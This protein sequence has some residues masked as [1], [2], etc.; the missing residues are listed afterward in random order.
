LAKSPPVT[1]RGYVNPLGGI[2]SGWSQD[3]NQFETND[4]LLWPRS[5]QTFT[6]MARD[7][8]R[9]SSILQAISLPIRLTSWRIDACGASDEVTRHVADDLGLPI[10]GDDEEYPHRR[11]KG[12]FSWGSHLQQALTYLQFGHSIFETI[13]RV[14]GGRIH[15]AK[16]APRPQSTIAWWN[17]ARDGGL[18]SVE[19][20]P[21]GLFVTP[22]LSVSSPAGGRSAIPISRLLVYVRDPDPGVWHGNSILRPAYKNYV[23]KDELLRIEA[24]AA[25][26]HGIGVPAAWAPPDESNDPERVAEYQKAASAYQGGSSAGIG[27]PAEARFEILGPTGSPM[28]P[29]RAIEY[30]DHQM[31]LVALAHFLNLDGKGGS[32]ALASVQQ[33]TFVQ[34]VGAVA[35]NIREVAQ[36]HVIDDI[37]DWNYGQDEPAPRLVF[38]AI[39]S[40]QD[41]TAVAMQQLVAA[42]LLTPDSRL[43]SFVRQMTG[44]PASDSSYTQEADDDVE[45]APDT[46]Q[47]GVE[48]PPQTL[49]NKNDLRLFDV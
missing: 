3:G 25:R 11:S 19:Q 20:W 33:D 24:A 17:V 5:V 48:P 36:A 14:D 4:D 37:V 1:E 26:R 9:L 27:L 38:D 45:E 15:L 40:R 39:G 8:S 31:A 28:D 32:Y 29:R 44:L 46:G 13:Y 22:G 16:L 34:A 6:R 42:G 21:A 2:M 49:S 10:V 23:L 18:I 35:E 41:A 43:E 47:V 12:R 30:H 7:D